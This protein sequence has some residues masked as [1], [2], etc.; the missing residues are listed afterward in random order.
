MIHTFKDENR[1]LSNMTLVN[2]HF[3]G[4]TFK[5]VEH[6]YQSAKSDSL[7]WKMFCYTEESPYKIKIKSK[8]ISIVDNWDDIKLGLMEGLLNQKF[9]QEPFK[10]QLLNTG[11]ENIQEGNEWGDKFWGVDL[12]SSPN[13]GENHL[14][15][16]IMKIRDKIKEE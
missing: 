16:L 10:T 15:R 6:A 12:K 5:S 11:D 1:W 13:I 4:L 8:E 3:D 14:G 9:R 7:D 2:I